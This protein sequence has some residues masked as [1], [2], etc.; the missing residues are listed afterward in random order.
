MKVAISG[1]IVRADYS[2]STEPTW[3]FSQC[4]EKPRDDD[5]RVAVCQHSFEVEVPDG[6]MIAERVAGVRAEIQRTY[7]NAEASVQRL[8]EQESKLLAL[9][10]EVPAQT[11][12][13]GDDIPL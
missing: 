4:R 13:V 12:E 3:E 1:W 5:D 2:W 8:R 6:P 7:A 10:N 9:T 11:V